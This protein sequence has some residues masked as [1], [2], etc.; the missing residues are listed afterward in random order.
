MHDNEGD[1]IIFYSRL[2]ADPLGRLGIRGKKHTYDELR[3][4]I[5][6][7]VDEFTAREVLALIKHGLL[8][9]PVRV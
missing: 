9:P 3:A 8:D 2:T 7:C 1:T 6:D 4:E 5:R